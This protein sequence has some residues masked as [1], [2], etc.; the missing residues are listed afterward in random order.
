MKQNESKD[1]SSMR[2]HALWIGS[3]VLAV[4]DGFCPADFANSPS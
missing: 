4:V 2:H 1:K 3:V